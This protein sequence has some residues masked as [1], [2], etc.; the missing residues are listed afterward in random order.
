MFRGAFT[1]DRAP[2]ARKQ[3]SVRFV[4]LLLFFFFFRN[5]ISL[6]RIN[7]QS[8][9][10]NNNRSVHHLYLFTASIYPPHVYASILRVTYTMPAVRKRNFAIFGCRP[11]TACTGPVVQETKKKNSKIKTEKTKKQ[12]RAVRC[13]T[14]FKHRSRYLLH[15]YCGPDPAFDLRWNFT[16]H[17]PP[18]SPGAPETHCFW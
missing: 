1:C 8:W 11:S 13:T 9:S 6:R 18:L 16:F 10:C 12:S 17:P 4:L 2:T 7:L 5:N 15:C 14:G 3:W